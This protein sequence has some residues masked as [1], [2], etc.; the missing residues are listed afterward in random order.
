MKT[1][2]NFKVKC[3]KEIN[4][5]LAHNKLRLEDLDKE[6][7]NWIQEDDEINQRE[8][9]D[10]IQRLQGENEAY[11]FILKL[12]LQKKEVKEWAVSIVPALVVAV[13]LVIVVN[14]KNADVK[15]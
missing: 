2:I 11:E 13:A 5:K 6:V 4:I 7:D 14:T 12:M 9:E 3:V 1:L 8:A 15:E 10:L